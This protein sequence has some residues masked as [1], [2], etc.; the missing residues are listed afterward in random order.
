MQGGDT[1]DEKRQIL[2]IDDDPI[3]LKILTSTL[4][5]Q[6]RVKTARDGE[7]GL[8][9]ANKYDIDLI[10][11]DIMMLKMSGHEV[12]STLK[13]N[14][15]T[16]DIPVIFITSKEE[17]SEEAKALS[18][19]AV[20]YIRKPID[21]E[22]VKLRVGIQMQLISQMQI[23]EKYSLTDSLTGVSNRRFFDQQM[24]AEWNR[25]ARNK[26]P[27]GL[28][29]LDIDNFK[30]FND[31]YGHI[32]GDY[33]LKTFANIIVSTVQ[34]KSDYVYRCG[35]EEFAVILPDTP[36]EGAAIVA[37]RIRLN[38]ENTP[39]KLESKITNITTS[40]SAGS[41]IP[42]PG[43]YP[44]GMTVFCEAMDK[45]LYA[46]KHNGRNRVEVLD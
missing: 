46:A 20:D 19:G 43:S 42:R 10:L 2:I 24:E 13:E 1:M 17:I 26:L 6:Y 18:S 36:K 21:Q 22:I 7:S 40:I 12:M 25:S 3:I 28:L 32:S 41:I 14:T 30:V 16:A 27:L 15:K 31:T 11:L 44:T 33:A 35:G 29:M 45:T 23:I 4:S 5:P 8:V 9:I 38:V 39:L 34:R 37:E